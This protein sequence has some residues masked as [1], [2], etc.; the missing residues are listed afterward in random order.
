MEAPATQPPAV[1]AVARV[2][3]VCD[4][5]L[6]A[7]D[8]ALQ[9]R[10]FGHQVSIASGL[11][12]IASL[13]AGVAPDCIVVDPSSRQSGLADP[14]GLLALRKALPADTP[15]LWLSPLNNFEMRLAAARAGVAAWISK[16]VDMTALH[17][18]IASLALRRPPKAA[19]VLVVAHDGKRLTQCEQVLGAAGMVTTGLQKPID[20]LRTLSQHHPELVVLD[21]QTS[22]CSGVDLTLLIRQDKAFLDLP[23]LVLAETEN[24]DA[25]RRALLAGADDFLVLPT[26]DEQLA[27]IAQARVERA[28]ALRALIMRDGLTGLYNHRAIKEHLAREIARSRRE[29]NPLSLAVV[30]LDFFKKIND[31]YGHP[32]GDQVIRAVSQIL[33][34]RLRQGDLVGRYGG[35]EFVVILPSTPAVAA[36]NVLN[37]IRAAFERIRHRTDDSEFGAT[38]SAGVAELNMHAAD[39]ETLFSLADAALYEAKQ[40]GRNQVALTPGH[41]EP[42]ESLL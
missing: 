24:P 10:C 34:Q 38:F 4:N 21:M 26:P 12:G 19:R 42:V 27:V 20:L 39:A 36:A 5:L 22:V 33:Q 28:R 35:E 8:T 31:S 41:A 7:R 32:V 25:H 15:L 40:G 23:I 11:A 29:G 18:R 14:A 6:L 3:L 30:D 2:G 9:L 13:Y 1:P 17:E 16:P 37:E